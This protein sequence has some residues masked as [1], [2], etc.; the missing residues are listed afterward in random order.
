MIAIVTDKLRF[1]DVTKYLAPRTSYNKY[2]SA[3]KVEEKKS[4]FCYE[5]LDSFEKLNKDCLPDDKHFNSTLKYY[6]VLE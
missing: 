6:N 3:F 2:L 5:Y 4:Y 1:S